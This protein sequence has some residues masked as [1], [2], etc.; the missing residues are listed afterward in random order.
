MTAYY[1]DF[2]PD[3]SDGH[4]ESVDGAQ[5]GQE[6]GWGAIG[7]WA[8]GLSRIL[9]QLEQ[10]EYIDAARV[11]ALGHSRLGKAALW[12]G[13]QDARFAA[14]ISN[15]SG[16]MGAAISRRRFGETVKLITAFYPH[17]FSESF[18]GYADREDELPVDQHQLLG[19]IAPRPV[20]VA[21]A[22]TDLWADPRGEF[23]AA[24]K[25]AELYRLYGMQTDSF[26]EMPAP[27][28]A[29]RGPVSYHLREG[30]HDM[31]P[32]DWAHFMDFADALDQ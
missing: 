26:A 12:A 7:V 18:I 11:I 8:W 15:N 1:G 4:L 22:S 31:L 3:H 24:A 25:V 21:S 23:T 32:F 10:N 13:A 2:Y 9:D 29:I 5:A 6:A 28:E 16:A 20:Y 17:W 14:V 19:L 30:G 27:G